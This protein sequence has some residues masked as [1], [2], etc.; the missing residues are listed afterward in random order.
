MTAIGTVGWQL[1]STAPMS[2]GWLAYIG[3]IIL[4]H[5]NTSMSLQNC[6]WSTIMHNIVLHKHHY[7]APNY[8]KLMA[9]HCSLMVSQVFDS[10]N[11]RGNLIIIIIIIHWIGE[12]SEWGI[13]AKRCPI[14]RII[15]QLQ[16]M[17]PPKNQLF[18]KGFWWSIW[19]INS[20]YNLPCNFVHALCCLRKYICKYVFSLLCD[21]VLEVD[22]WWIK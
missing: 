19:N 2:L 15:H 1:R 22:R 12:P 4:L 20:I 9:W 5:Q 3:V 21:M 16:N 17:A 11:F 7:A 6:F 14:V 13:A 10:Q 18:L 8:T